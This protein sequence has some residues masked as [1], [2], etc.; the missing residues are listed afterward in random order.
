MVE[1]KLFRDWELGEVVKYEKG[2]ATIKTKGGL[3]G[4][5]REFSL[6]EIRSP[7]TKVLG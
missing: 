5:L 2:K 1:Y 7:M 4:N 3:S 6:D